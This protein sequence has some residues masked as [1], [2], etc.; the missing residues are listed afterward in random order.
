[1]SFSSWILTCI[2]TNIWARDPSIRTE[3]NPN[4]NSKTFLSQLGNHIADEK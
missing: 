4:D 2:A 1:M 3:S